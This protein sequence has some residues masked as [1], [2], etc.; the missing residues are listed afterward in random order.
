VDLASAPFYTSGTFWAA[1]A[2]AVAVLIGV[3]T[4][5]VTWISPYPKR[6]LLYSMPVVTSMLNRQSDLTDELKVIY[7]TKKLDCPTL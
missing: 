4:M 6:R 7:G 1:A 5:W 3:A 2:V